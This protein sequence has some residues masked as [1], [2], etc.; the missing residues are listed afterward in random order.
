MLLPLK[1]IELLNLIEKNYTKVERHFNKYQET[2]N[3]FSVSE[4]RVSYYNK[5]NVKNVSQEEAVDVWNKEQ[6]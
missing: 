5:M 2:A 3:C 1:I 6:S 4:Q